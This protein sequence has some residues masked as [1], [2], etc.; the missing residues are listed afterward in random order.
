MVAANPL[1]GF[2]IAGEEIISRGLPYDDS[3]GGR[4]NAADPT[5]VRGLDCSS[6]VAL[7]LI[8][9]GE[10]ID[11]CTNSW[12]QAAAC[13]A[14]MRPDWMNQQIGLGVGSQVPESYA[15]NVPGVLWFHMSGVGHVEVGLGEG[16]KSM[17]AHSHS[18][19]IGYGQWFPGF[20]DFYAIWPTLTPYFY[21]KPLPKVEPQMNIQLRARLRNPGGQGHVGGWWEGY[22]NGLVDFLGDDGTI[23]HGGM[24]SV[25][26]LKN[27]AEHGEVLARLEPRMYGH[28][29]KHGYTIIA[30]DGNRY[31]PEAQV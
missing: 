22:D 1:D 9:A 10:S 26:D 2:L 31:V 25:Y 4:C 24:N 3:L 19:G 23:A 11:P 13:A 27:F 14:F 6:F 29:P 21:V 28:P 12:A 20:F 17:G 16:G 7:A 15:L 18:Q 30:E 5:N 8:M